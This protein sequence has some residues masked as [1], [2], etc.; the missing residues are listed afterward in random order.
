MNYTLFKSNLQNL[1]NRGKYG[2][3][4]VDVEVLKTCMDV[5]I[6]N[7]RLAVDLMIAELTIE[8]VSS[9]SNG[10]VRAA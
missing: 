2:R 8:A 3:R 9:V 4:T 7:E 1:I 6:E 10:I 5:V